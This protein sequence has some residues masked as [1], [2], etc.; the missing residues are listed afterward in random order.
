MDAERRERIR[1]SLKKTAEK[2]KHQLC[3]VFELKVDKSRLNK[4]QKEFLKMLFIEA[5]WFYNDALSQK[6]PFKAS[7]K[8]KE[9]IGYNKNGQEVKHE[10]KH[11]GSSI[12]VSITQQIQQQIV[13]LNCKKKK[14]NKIGKLKFKSDFKTLELKNDAYSIQKNGTIRIQKLAKPFFVHGLEQLS[15]VYELANAK[16]CKKPSGYYIKITTYSYPSFEIENK[17][18]KDIGIDFGI[19]DN[20]TTSDGKKFNWS[21]EETERLKKLQRKL[22]RAKKNSNNRQKL[23]KNIAIEYEKLTNR[24][25]DISNKFVHFLL[26]KYRII[27]IQDDNFSEWKKKENNRGSKIHSSILG[28]IKKK[29]KESKQVVVV[30]RYA[31]TTKQCYKCGTFNEIERG[32]KVFL[33]S[34]CGLSEDRDIKAAK[35]IISFGKMFVPMDRRIMLAEDI[36]CLN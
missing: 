26:T 19:R 24:K 8:K 30:E 20:V 21:I 9:V 16:L 14:G 4:I 1:Q 34:R 2:R 12:R 33:C 11:L 22:A 29:L 18:K 27:Y 5:K 35:T 10:I 25:N 15:S 36:Q 3:K 32:D 31:P 6:E 13:A 17:E 23:L 7:Y 28:R